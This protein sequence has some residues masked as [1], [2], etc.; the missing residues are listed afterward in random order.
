MLASAALLAQAGDALAQSVSLATAQANPS[1]KNGFRSQDRYPLWISKADCLADDSYTFVV[2]VQNLGSTPLF[3][4]ASAAGQ[5][6]SDPTTRSGTNARCWK[7]AEIS[8][9]SGATSYSITL[10]VRDIVGGYDTPSSFNPGATAAVCE[11]TGNDAPLGVLLHFLPVQAAGGV[12]A[13]TGFQY[14]EIKFDLVPPSAP[15]NVSAGIG[16]NVLE[17][18]WTTSLSTDISGYQFYC[19]PAPGADAPASTTPIGTAGSA[20]STTSASSSSSCAGT[21]GAAGASGSTGSSGASGTAG[22][23]GTA[24]ASGTGGSSFLAAG[25]GGFAGDAGAAGSAGDAGAAGTAGAGAAAGAAGSAG[26]AGATSSGG[27]AGAS[28]TGGAAGTGGAGGTSTAGAAGKS[29]TSGAAGC[30]TTG[31]TCGRSTLIVGGT[32]GPSGHECGRATGN[33][34]TEGRT[35]TLKNGVEYSVAVAAIDN[36]GNVGRISAPQC[37]APA[38]IEDFYGVYVRS[39]GQAGGG[40]CQT[41]APG[42]GSAALSLGALAAVVALRAARRRR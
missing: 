17:L 21:S 11:R 1:R 38:Q 5:D 22:T 13:G 20:G 12:V 35:S 8:A 37:L 33:T 25:A 14:N 24:G 10:P 36:V 27:A 42:T 15:T 26:A 18:S 16:D 34:A 2:Q 31:A 40:W 7:L 30:A 41:S 6:C 28:G 3:V 19:D 29:G 23:A 39:G 4:F 9:Q 32:Y